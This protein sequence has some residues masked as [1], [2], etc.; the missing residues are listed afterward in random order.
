[1]SSGHFKHV[2]RVLNVLSDRVASSMDLVV[3]DGTISVRQDASDIIFVYSTAVD[4]AVSRQSSS[5]F[6]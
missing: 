3:P 1:V 4:R 6:N 2:S 5:R